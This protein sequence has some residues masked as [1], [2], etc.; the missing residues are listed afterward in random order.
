MA[1][2]AVVHHGFVPTFRAPFFERLCAT[3]DI[4][5]VIFHGEPPPGE[6]FRAAAEPYAFVNHRV[7]N[8]TLRVA[9][10]SV[11]WQSI[12]GPIVR[13]DYDAAVLGA[14]LKF[15]ANLAVAG[16]LRAAGRPVVIWGQGVDKADDLGGNAIRRVVAGVKPQIARMA[17]GYLAYTDRGRSRLEAVGVDPA[18]LTVVRNTLDV[19]AQRMLHERLASCDEPALR[20]SLGV[21]RDAVVLLYV[22]RVYR[23]KR[24]D[25]LVELARELAGRE[26]LPPVEIVVIGDGPD[27]DRV[28]QLAAGVPGVRFEG[29]VYEPE[30]LARWL[31]AATALVI[32][33]KVGLAVNH[34]LA[35]GVPVLTRASDLHAPEVEYLHH[36]VNGLLVPGSHADF[37]AAVAAV[38]ADPERQRALSEGALASRDGLDLGVMVA[39]FDGGVRRALATA[40]RRRR[41][42]GARA[43]ST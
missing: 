8:R 25:E 40:P 27:L 41:P 37:C 32:P 20:D 2:V 9:G 21:A 6:G 36:D 29:E 23:E 22:G 24:V 7:R 3:S 42:R 5:Y 34:A 19:G 15:P 16:A 30:T 14:E 39:A 13:G 31:R 38:A 33:G 35:H 43:R 17:N 10:R 11:V 1:R 4:E 28:Q 12:L 18:R 26:G